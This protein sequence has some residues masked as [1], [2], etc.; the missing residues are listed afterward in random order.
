MSPLVPICGSALVGQ[1]TF[2]LQHA[3]LSNVP[4]GEVGR[5]ER[6]SDGEA[7]PVDNKFVHMGVFPS[8]TQLFD[9]VYS[10]PRTWGANHN[11]DHDYD[12]G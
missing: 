6:S 11:R 1:S 10:C 2:K 12:K 7:G 9:N 5:H 8:G 4:P 3:D